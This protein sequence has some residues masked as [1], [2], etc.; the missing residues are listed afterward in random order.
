MDERLLPLPDKP[1]PQGEHILVVDDTPA[2][3]NLIAGYL[4]EAGYNVEI[5][6]NAEEAW[7]SLLQK[8]P[9]LITVD[10]FL[11]GVSGLGL[12]YRL[13]DLSD[14]GNIWSNTIMIADNSM[15]EHLL[16]GYRQPLI[17][18]YLTKPFNPKELLWSVRRILKT[19]SK[20]DERYRI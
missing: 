1:I 12:C 7:E 10:D 18:I 5:A 4:C 20:G 8:L 19:S 11:P 2:M 6:H 16:W 14:E 3:A 13:R 17:S 9:L 15:P